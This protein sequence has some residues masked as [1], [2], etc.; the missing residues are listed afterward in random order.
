MLASDP[1]ISG[2]TVLHIILIIYLE[3]IIVRAFR[4]YIAD[5][6]AYELHPGDEK[7]IAT[8]S[9][10]DKVLHYTYDKGQLSFKHEFV[11]LCL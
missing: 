4:T 10:H 3:T 11:F 9:T 7:F 1:T 8:L 6:N 2:L 5:V